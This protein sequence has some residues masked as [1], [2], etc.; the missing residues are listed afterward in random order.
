MQHGADE[1]LL[2]PPWQGETPSSQ[3]HSCSVCEEQGPSV[4]HG[5]LCWAEQQLA[6]YSGCK[7]ALGGHTEIFCPFLLSS[8]SALTGNAVSAACGSSS[9]QVPLAG[10]DMSLPWVLQST[11]IWMWNLSLICQPWLIHGNH[12]LVFLTLSSIPC[13][14]VMCS[15]LSLVFQLLNCQKN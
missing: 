3:S 4:L 13:L 10:T 1:A 7:R 8:H 11:E 12:Q 15:L 14:Q 5:Q 6:L 9:L 2:A